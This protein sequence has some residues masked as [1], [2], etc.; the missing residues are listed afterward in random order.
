MFAIPAFPGINEIKC[1]LAKTQTQHLLNTV[2]GLIT[3]ANLLCWEQEMRNGRRQNYRKLVILAEP[4]YFTEPIPN[5]RNVCE[6]ETSIYSVESE[7]DRSRQNIAQKL[8]RRL[9]CPALCCSVRAR[10]RTH[11]HN[12]T[13]DVAS[14][15]F[16][17]SI[18]S[19]KRDNE[20]ADVTLVRDNQKAEK[21]GRQILEWSYRSCSVTNCDA[22]LSRANSNCSS[23]STDSEC[24]NPLKTKRRLLYLKT[25]FVPRS[26]HFS[27]RL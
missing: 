16:I 7:T 23:S 5:R 14:F 4:C 22:Y 26:K 17:R 6:R 3:W 13:I 20:T 9:T 27:S 21:Q 8:D 19:T 18:Q 15:P 25:Q 12:R 10:T 1:V 2:T 24:V 11:T